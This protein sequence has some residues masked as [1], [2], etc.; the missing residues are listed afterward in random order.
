M[1]RGSKHW[2]SSPAWGKRCVRAAYTSPLPTPTIFAMQ[3]MDPTQI[4]TTNI[5]QIMQPIQTHPTNQT[6]ILL[7]RVCVCVCL[8]VQGVEPNWITYGLVFGVMVDRAKWDDATHLLRWVCVCACVVV[9]S[10]VVWADMGGCGCGCG[11]IVFQK[12]HVCTSESS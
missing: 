7:T 9:A 2:T 4:H 1:T 10:V 3:G 12:E 11:W 5:K 6:N 8:H